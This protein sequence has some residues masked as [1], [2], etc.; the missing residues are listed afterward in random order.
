MKRFDI[1]FL[2]FFRPQEKV[3]TG[4]FYSN[5]VL[6]CLFAL[7]FTAFWSASCGHDSA[8]S[9]IKLGGNR[10]Q[11]MIDILADVKRK[12]D[13][14]RNTFSV[15]KKLKNI[16]SLSLTAKTGDEQINF[17][18]QKAAILLEYGDEAQA[19]FWYEKIMDVV[20]DIPESRKKVLPA[21]GVAYMRLAERNNCV[22]G[23][24][25]ESCV[26]PIRGDGIHQNKVAARKAI[27]V[28]ETVLKED[29]TNL[30]VQWLLNIAYMTIGEYPGNVP[31][32]WLVP[33]LD[34]S[35]P[36]TV[37]SFT[38]MAEDLGIAVNNRGG[39]AIV[40]DF[41]NDGYLDIITSSWGLDDPM[42]FF[43]NNGD[44]TFQDASV[45]SGLN[46]LLGGINMVQTDYNND[47][48]IDVFVLRG[49]W[50]G[51][52]GF[53]EQPNS[54][55]R[56]NGD[57]TFTDVTVE[58]GLLSFH[59]TQTATW[60]DFNKDGWLDLFIGNETSDP[61]KTHP[62]EFYINNQDGTFTNIA[63]TNDFNVVAFVKGV[64]SGDYDNDGWP[65]I[66]IS[67]LNSQKLLLHN[68][69]IPGKVP[70]FEEVSQ[71]AGFAGDEQRSF[72]TGFFDYDNDG[73]LDLFACNY[74][75]GPPLSYFAAKEALHPSGD[76]AGKLTIY[77]NNGNGT[78]TD[79]SAKMHIN[80]I[81]FAMGANFGDFDNDG[82][83]DLFFGTGNPD[84]R[85]LIPNRLYK[86]ING[87]D[88]A[89]VTV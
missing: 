49:A 50:Q 3:K 80:Q 52:S 29:P 9:T 15:E 24:N 76:R 63:N 19:V 27:K 5:T 13:D 40:E 42:H 84:Y 31:A 45:S 64:T 55:L 10:N 65:D 2:R 54:L 78:F 14:Y 48:K 61:K 81:V 39:G 71:K 82:W 21:L 72:P 30:D 17:A 58:S 89:E 86:N 87:K 74:E 56:N 28:F 4:A 8:A 12:M 67:S 47:G 38:D 6:G 18:F 33:N 75:F 60:N 53:G 23:H 20:K 57:G 62:C 35:G 51:Q 83:L 44:G 85:S 70:T 43:I 41:T 32:K 16:D 73:W 34:K 1:Q 36:V 69:G 79:V 22:N 88:F 46:D 11:K 25:A 77:H 66:F 59:P 37:K 68:K 26:M 7:F